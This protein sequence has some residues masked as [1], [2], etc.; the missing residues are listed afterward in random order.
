MMASGG[1]HEEPPPAWAW[2]A[3]A[4]AQRCEVFKELL[5][6][7]WWYMAITMEEVWS[8]DLLSTSD[9]IDFLQESDVYAVLSRF[10]FLLFVWHW[11]NTL[12]QNTAAKDTH[13]PLPACNSRKK[14]KNAKGSR[15]SQNYFCKLCT[16]SKAWVHR[17]VFLPCRFVASRR[18]KPARIKPYRKAAATRQYRLHFWHEGRR[19][20]K[21]QIKVRTPVAGQMQTTQDEHSF[22]QAMSTRS[23]FFGGAAG[24]NRTKRERKKKNAEQLSSL[25]QT[26]LQAIKDDVPPD[27]MQTLVTTITNWQHTPSRSQDHA[28]TWA[29]TQQTKRPQQHK[30]WSDNKTKQRPNRWARQ[31]TTWTEWKEQPSKVVRTNAWQR[32]HKSIA[33]LSQHEWTLPVKVAS[34][35]ATRQALQNGTDLPGNVVETTTQLE[36]MDLKDLWHAVSSQQNFTILATGEAMQAPQGTHT[37]ITIKHKHARSHQLEPASLHALGDRSKCPWVRPNSKVEIPKSETPQKVTVRLTIPTHYRQLFSEKAGQEKPME[38]M[39]TMA[40]SC[41]IP[42]HHLGGGQ[43]KGETLRQKEQLVGHLKVPKL[44]A[45]TLVK[46]SGRHGVFVTITQ[47]HKTTE[48]VKWCQ[49][50]PGEDNDN[51][52]RRASSDA[53]QH[54]LGL[55]YRSGG[56]SDLGRV[57]TATEVT[58]PR[59]TTIRV[60]DVPRHWEPD[61]IAQFLHTQHWKDAQVLTK[62]KAPAHRGNRW[63]FRA[64]PP[65][66]QAAQDTWVYE[67]MDGNNWIFVSKAPPRLPKVQDSWQV[68]APKPVW[69]RNKADASRSSNNAAEPTQI[70]Q[71]DEEDEAADA[72]MTEPKEVNH[73][74]PVRTTASK[75]AEQRDRSRSPAKTAKSQEKAAAAQQEQ[76]APKEKPKVGN[77]WIDNDIL[78]AQKQGWSR[79]D[80]GGTGDCGYRVLCCGIDQRNVAPEEI[81][82]KAGVLRADTLSHIRKHYARYSAA[83]APER[84]GDPRTLEE[85]LEKAKDPSFYIE[86]MQLQAAC[87]R[88]GVPL[89][90]WHKHANGDNWGRSVFAPKFNQNDRAHIAKNR[91]PV[92]MV[93]ENEHYQ[94][95]QPPEDLDEFPSR[96]LQKTLHLSNGAYRGAAES[97]SGTPSVY[98]AASSKTPSVHTFRSNARKRKAGTIQS[99]GLTHAKSKTGAPSLRSAKYKAT[100]HTSSAASSAHETKSAVAPQKQSAQ[101]GKHDSKIRSKT[102]YR[103]HRDNFTWTCN[104]CQFVVR[105]DTK[106]KCTVA[107]GHHLRNF[108]PDTRHLATAAFHKPAEIIPVSSLPAEQRSWTCQRCG[109]GLPSLASWSWRK[110]KAAHTKACAD[111]SP[112][113]IYYQNIR[114]EAGRQACR[115]KQ[116]AEVAARKAVALENMQK[117]SKDTGHTLV[118]L[119]FGTHGTRKWS[120]TCQ[121]CTIRRCTL[122][123]IKKQAPQ[124]QSANCRTAAFEQHNR[125]VWWANGREFD[126]TSQAFSHFHAVLQAWKIT[127]QEMQALETKSKT[128]RAPPLTQCQWYRDL[129]EEGIEPNPG[130]RS[131]ARAT[132]EIVTANV[133]GVENAWHCAHMVIDRQIDV[134]ILQET[135]FTEQKFADFAQFCHK[136]HYQVFEANRPDFTSRDRR[137]YGVGG[138]VILVHKKR[139]CKPVQ[140]WTSAEGDA[141]VVDLDFAYV[142]GIYLPPKADSQPL[143]QFLHECQLSTRRGTP[144]FVLGDWNVEPKSWLELSGQF[145]AASPKAVMNTDLSFAPTRWEGKRCLDWAWC[146]EPHLVKQ[147][148]FWTEKIADHKVVQFTA[149]AAETCAARCT[150]VPTRRL[151][152]PT[153]VDSETWAQA[154]QDSWGSATQLPWS[155][156]VNTDWQNF[157]AKAELMHIEALNQVGC[158]ANRKGRFRPKGSLP[159][160]EFHGKYT[161]RAKQ[162]MPFRIRK[163]RNLLGRALEAKRQHDAGNIQDARA[164]HHKLQKNRTVN[165]SGSSIASCVTCLQE[166]VR[167]EDADD[168]ANKLREW[169]RRMLDSDAAAGA[170]AKRTPQTPSVNLKLDDKTASST[171]E[172]LNLLRQ[173]W[174]QIWNREVAFLPAA[175]QWLS[176]CPCPDNQN[177]TWTPFNAKEL[178]EQAQKMRPSAPGLDGWSGA[179]LADW[180]INTWSAFAHFANQCFAAAQ[181]PEAFQ[182]TRQIFLLK[183]G[184]QPDSNGSFSCNQTRPISVQCTLWRVLASTFVRR[185]A[186][187]AWIATWAPHNAFGAIAGRGVH[188]AVA[189]LDAEFRKS[190][191]NVLVSLDFCKCFDFIH[192]DIAIAALQKVGAP[193]ELLCMCSQLWNSQQRWLC[194]HDQCL[195][196]PVQV[197][198]SLPQG[199]ALSPLCLIAIM[200][201]LSKAVEQQLDNT[202][203]NITQVT[204]LD[205]R[206]VIA[207]DPQSARQCVDAWTSL[208]AQ[209]GL[210]ENQSKLKVCPATSVFKAA[211]QAAGFSEQ[212][213]V[214]S[215]RVLGVDFTQNARSAD[216]VV[217]TSRIKQAAAT[218]K[219]IGLLPHGV[220]RRSRLI[221][222][223]ALPKACWGLWTFNPHA[224]FFAAV[225]KAIADALFRNNTSANSPLRHLLEGHHMDPFFRAGVQAVTFFRHLIRG[226][227]TPWGA[228][229]KLGT[230]PHRVCT[231]L[232]SL[233]WRKQANWIWTHDHLA[234]ISLEANQDGNMFQ[235]VLHQLRMSWRLAKWHDFIA[236]GRREANAAADVPFCEQRYKLTQNW[237]ERASSHERAVLSGA[238]VSP[239]RFAVMHKQEIPQRCHFCQKEE[240]PSWQHVCWECPHFANTRP[241]RPVCPLTFVVGWP[242]R[243]SEYSRLVLQHMAQVRALCLSDRY[244]SA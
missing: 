164:I 41:A 111:M 49:R 232:S 99:G 165:L 231:F 138:V 2:R 170:W 158:P 68:P 152:R 109:L 79:I 202:S 216:R 108:H 134:A 207:P 12:P 179:E 196:G 148:S 234:E 7:W 163:L 169:K 183:E 205:D 89:V 42:A 217:A 149:Q 47:V 129:C 59:P 92:V 73:E 140:R 151:Q 58:E 13:T 185:S 107:R 71:E 187:K 210:Q 137:T 130:P 220:F 57:L 125:S 181:L 86:G 55:K 190:N 5:I 20:P 195:P 4:E 173:Y 161:V 121:T 93:L 143:L 191:T 96:W 156:D 235:L 146:S 162:L 224:K 9:F 230:W 62:Q 22:A 36:T 74:R 110:S 155:G 16:K 176:N 118:M 197:H 211:L 136:Q 201:F 153:E 144:W 18:C 178:R 218:V 8:S 128:T 227:C 199:D 242:M 60:Q 26:V 166:M 76:P 193:Q 54:T 213:I 80:K 228:R 180:P 222:M 119:P 154:L 203:R 150:L 124:C 120:F 94:W 160:S 19:A 223:I 177:L 85:W 116:T 241:A 82:R 208:S 40:A 182:A 11:S 172:A 139:N 15:R 147:C 83:Y 145:P 171:Q 25:L 81:V 90:V 141:C 103:S 131:K 17:P 233:G 221:S 95:L 240:V 98:T 63:L 43:W 45:E 100:R 101:H 34:A 29:W 184:S 127:K 209:V 28:E 56:G 112:K 105:K 32:R 70:D 33:V 244:D 104:L 77:F 38:I 115:E 66:T 198:T 219:R 122:A 194:F 23:W 106:H 175:Q 132:I 39:A 214:D 10:L 243:D 200:T 204:F 157:C 14:S 65:S 91:S 206:T 30:Q 142:A 3:S 225:N 192:P 238:S 52:F 69:G 188:H 215:M 1:C 174:A 6:A 21:P 133:Q 135:K 72:E 113:D 35:Q 186:T 114:S 123:D 237:F 27:L 78:S 189:T 48:K 64:T 67:G 44:I 84:P 50:Q 168:S 212:Q 117:L 229:C 87:E 236:S 126:A 46:N 159:K 61:D 239:A 226:H 31:E 167:K 37:R 102:S 75:E 88:K 24:A 53:A 97:N 51:Y